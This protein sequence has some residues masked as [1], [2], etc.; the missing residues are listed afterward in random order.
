MPVVP[1]LASITVWPGLSAFDFSAAA[2]PAGAAARPKK[3]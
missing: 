3:I 2:M 1:P